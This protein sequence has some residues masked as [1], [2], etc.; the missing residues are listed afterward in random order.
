VGEWGDLEGCSC[1]VSIRVGVLGVS[2]GL[3]VGVCCECISFPI[4]GFG[5]KMP[6]P[7]LTISWKTS[8][9][10]CRRRTWYFSLFE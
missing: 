9:V 4:S 3:E 5:W 7:N 10:D 6:L 1:G 8:C 2:R